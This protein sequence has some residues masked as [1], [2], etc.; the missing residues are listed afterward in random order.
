[1]AKKGKKK[2]ETNA[3]Y[4]TKINENFSFSDKLRRLLVFKYF[5]LDNNKTCQAMTRLYDTSGERE[6]NHTQNLE[7]HLHGEILTINI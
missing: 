7:T 2:R 6:Q 4:I 3:M 5:L 1:M